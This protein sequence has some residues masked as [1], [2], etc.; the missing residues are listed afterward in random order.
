M[1]RKTVEVGRRTVSYL[2]GGNLSK[3]PLVLLHGWSM[4]ASTLKK[5]GVLLEERY[6]VFIPDLPGFGGSDRLEA[7]TFASFAEFVQ[8]F[9]SALGLTSVTLVGHSMGGGVAI[10]VAASHP[11]SIDSIV[12]MNSAGLTQERSLLGWVLAAVKKT[13]RGF[14]ENPRRAAKSIVTAGKNMRRPVW[15]LKTYRMITAAAMED[16]EIR[17]ITTFGEVE[18]VVIQVEKDDFFQDQLSMAQV[19]GVKAINLEG[20]HD[21]PILRPAEV[22]IELLR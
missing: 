4:D 8:R 14:G 22:A 2:T 3:A 13:I 21:L 7:A 19:F 10:K 18:V 9:I 6:N 20:S 11:E 16:D 5:L 12:L 1:E 15:L 17:K